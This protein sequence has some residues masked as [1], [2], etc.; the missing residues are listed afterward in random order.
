[1]EIKFKKCNK[2][3]TLFLIIL[4]KIR[5]MT[6]HV[7]CFLSFIYIKYVPNIY[8][9]VKRPFVTMLTSIIS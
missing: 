3:K 2:F 6:R 4:K 5:M 8:F 7:S 1:M 9:T